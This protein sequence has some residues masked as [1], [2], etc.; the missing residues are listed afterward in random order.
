MGSHISTVPNHTF[1]SLNLLQ[2]NFDTVHSWFTVVILMRGAFT[3]NCF[4][5][6]KTLSSSADAFLRTHSKNNQTHYA[7]LLLE[8]MC[9]CRYKSVISL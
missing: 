5:L 6:I 1:L 2:D 3:P 8:D 4:D 9:H 7:T